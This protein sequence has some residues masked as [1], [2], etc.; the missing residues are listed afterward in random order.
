MTPELLRDWRRWV[1][2]EREGRSEDADAAFRAVFHAVPTHLPGDALTG[3][4]VQTVARAAARQARLAKLAAATGAVVAVALTIAVLLQL[5]RFLRAMVEFSVRTVIWTIL[6]FERGLDAWTILVQ[7]ARAVGAVLL[8][9]QVTI[10]MMGL[11][12]L[13]VGALYA[14]NRML[15]PEERSS[16]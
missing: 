10:A 12:L 5:P 6:A 2:A 4:V 11:G 1:D 13:A 9:P 7:A 16:L 15:E 8:A 14:L 3:R